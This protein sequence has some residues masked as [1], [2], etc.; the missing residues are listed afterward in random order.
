MRQLRDI[1]GWSASELAIYTVPSIEAVW[2]LTGRKVS[3]SQ[4]NEGS[5][6]GAKRC[7]NGKPH[8]VLLSVTQLPLSCDWG[9]NPPLNLSSACHCRGLSSTPQGTKISKGIASDEAPDE[10]S[11]AYRSGGFRQHHNGQHAVPPA[12]IIYA[13]D[14]T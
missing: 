3:S 12:K 1:K 8:I 10:F 5:S 7:T 14:I 9:G 4:E 13:Q 11:G 6:K 2:S